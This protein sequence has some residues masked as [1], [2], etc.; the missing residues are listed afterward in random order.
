MCFQDIFW[1][2]RGDLIEVLTEM[3]CLAEVLYVKKHFSTNC[4]RYHSVPRGGWIGEG[5]SWGRPYFSTITSRTWGWNWGEQNLISFVEVQWKS[6]RITGAE[7]Y[8]I[9]KT[10]WSGLEW[11]SLTKQENKKDIHWFFYRFF[12]S[13]WRGYEKDAGV[14]RFSYDSVRI[15]SCRNV[16]AKIA[17]RA[18]SI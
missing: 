2:Y 9:I 1:P 16:A 6:K 18:I 8:Y 14:V 12:A 7:L 10:W 11:D 3:W 17:N 13:L 15:S 4:V 5:G